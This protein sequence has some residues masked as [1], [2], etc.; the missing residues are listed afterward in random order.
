VIMKYQVVKIGRS[1]WGVIEQGKTYPGHVFPTLQQAKAFS[2]NKCPHCQQT[3]S[4]RET[5]DHTRGNSVG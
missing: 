5:N 1:W 4:T 3:L 2:E